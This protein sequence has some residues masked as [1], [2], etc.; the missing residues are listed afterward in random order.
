MTKKIT[1][2][3][4]CI[5]LAVSWVPRVQ[6]ASEEDLRQSIQAQV[7]AYAG[8][9]YRKNAADDTVDVML[10]QALYGNGKTLHFSRTDAVTAALYESQLLRTCLIENLCVAVPVML[11]SQTDAVLFGT[12]ALGW[13]DFALEYRVSQYHYNDTAT[14]KDDVALARHVPQTFYSG[15]TNGCDKAMVL[16]VGSCQIRIRIHLL[17]KNFETATLRVEVVVSDEFEFDGNYNEAE[18]MGF[19][20]TFS[21]LV[22]AL[23]PL[24]GMDEFFWDSTSSFDITVPLYYRCEHRAQNYRWEHNGTD[25]VA[26]QGEGLTA[27]A[28]NRVEFTNSD[29]SRHHYYQLEE[30]I[31][32]RHNVPWVLEFRQKGSAGFMLASDSMLNTGEP[33]FLRT[34]NHM[35]VGYYEWDEET[36]GRHQYGC[37]LTT[38]GYSHKE[39][40]TFRIENRIAGDGSNMLWLLVDGQEIGPMT[41]YYYNPTYVNI[42]METEDSWVSGKDFTVSCIGGGQFPIKG[43]FSYVA[44]W[45]MGEGEATEPFTAGTVQP[46][47]TAPGYSTRTCL[48]CGYV[49]AA[50]KTSALGHTEKRLPGTA[51]GCTAEGITE[52]IL[53]DVCGETLK[54]QEILPALGHRESVIPAVSPTCSETGLTEGNRCDTCGEILKA[55]EPIPAWG[56]RYEKGRCAVCGQ[57]DP[58]FLTGDA[59]FDGVLTYQDALLILQAS[60]GLAECDT[61]LCDTDGDGLLTYQDA[62]KVLRISIGL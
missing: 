11:E 25:F 20:T 57:P 14:A 12:D 53:C 7:E 5:L 22:S 8:S 39:F 40:H 13:H 34:T 38:L 43:E 61:E 31:T 23:G 45:E 32:L 52:G 49:E 15:A 17:E 58:D 37:E 56:H 29:G 55:Q 28:A 30:P 46:T 10:K 2:L 3:M 48:F 6:A 42:D 44:I 21:K 27:V 33:Y 26:A 1:A 62:L 60:I 19:D 41:H 54:A 47:C 24:L 50:E 36:R 18:K 35:H 4:L 16:V 51:A 9:I 59:N